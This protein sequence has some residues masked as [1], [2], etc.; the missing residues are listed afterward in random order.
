[1]FTHIGDV[2]LED[3]VGA[4]LVVGDLGAQSGTAI[5]RGRLDNLQ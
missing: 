3:G 1:M 4:L 5:D 2:L